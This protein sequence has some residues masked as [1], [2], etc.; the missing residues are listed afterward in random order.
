MRIFNYAAYAEAFELGVSKPN[1]TKITKA[2]FE[3]IVR[4]DGVVNHVGNLYTIN[5]RQRLLSV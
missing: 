5:Q 2:L 3:P 4:F 1:M